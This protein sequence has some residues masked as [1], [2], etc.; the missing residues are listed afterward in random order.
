MQME[1]SQLLV[2]MEANP[3]SREIIAGVIGELAEIVYLDDLSETQRLTALHAATALLSRNTAKELRDGEAEQLLNTRLIQFVSAGIDFIPLSRFPDAAVIAGNGGGYAEPMAEHAVMMALAAFKR[4]I[5]EH[6][7]V[8]CGAFNQ[9]KRNRMLAGSVCG[10][11]GFGGIGIETARLMRA[12]GV[13]VHAINRSGKTEQ[14]VDWIGNTSQTDELLRQS[15]ILILSLPLTPAT[16][17]LIGERELGLMKNDAVIINLARGEIIDEAALYAHLQNN[18]TFT[19]CIDAW[20]VEPVRHGRFEMNYP[21]LKLDNV[22]ASPHNSATVGRWRPVA[23]KRAAENVARL[24][25]GE[26]VLFRV[27]PADRMM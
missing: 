11:L 5:V 15:D 21:F 25:R 14:P 27:P 23:L 26:E 16:R 22:I 1:R 7:E 13:N 18:P 19:A 6:N 20:W 8:A 4:L 10:V 12:L 17:G 3:D 9:F 2:T 24:F